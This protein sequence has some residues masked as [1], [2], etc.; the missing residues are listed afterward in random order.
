[1][2]IISRFSSLFLKIVTTS[3]LFWILLLQISISYGQDSTTTQWGTKPLK[4]NLNENGSHWLALHTYAQFWMRGTENNPGSLLSDQPQNNTFD[5]SIRRFRLGIQAQLTEKLFV[6]SQLGI[7][8]L[9]Y[10]S[11]RG[12]STDLLD[13][14]AEYSFSEKVAI[15]AGKTAWTGL[16]R[17]SAPNTSKLLSYDMLLLALPTTDETNDLIRKLS[18]Y[19]KGKLGG[20]DYRMV[21]S[22]PFSPRNSPNF[23]SELIED[24]ARFTDKSNGII[25]SGYFKWEFLEAEG[26]AIPFSDGAHLGKKKVFNIG[27][28]TEFQRNALASLQNDETRFHDMYLWAADLFLDLPIN[29]KNNYALTVYLGYFDYDFGPNYIRNT[30]V[31][32]PITDIDLNQ[33]SFNGPGNAYPVVGT[34]N[35][36]YTQLGYLLPNLGRTQ[37][38]GRLQPYFSLQYSDFELLTNPMVAYDFGLNW[39]LKEH[40]SKFSLNLQARP[41]YQET[42]EGVRLDSRKWAAVLQYIIRLE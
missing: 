11:S 28:G 12:T 25:Y 21:F 1:M 26:N 10:L 20:L 5:I 34:G 39:Y 23:D 17:Y 13:A 4:W 3:I 15:G 36:L 35:S 40:L 24:S 37:N 31:N 33:G 29:G 16:S 6:Y 2:K 22:K 32:N 30:G 27:I 8:N 14:Y 19:T 18:I 38:Y 41:V 9:N 7:N 42:S